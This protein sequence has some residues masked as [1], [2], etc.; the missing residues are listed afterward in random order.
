MVWFKVDDGFYEH[1][2]VVALERYPARI[3]ALALA[4]WTLAGSMSGSRLTDGRVEPWTLRKR[5]PNHRPRDLT[6][7][8]TALVEVGL[9]SRSGSTLVEVGSEFGRTCAG[10]ALYVFADWSQYQPTKEQVLAKRGRD[11]GRKRAKNP[12]VVAN[13]P[14][15]IHAESRGSPQGVAT[16]SERSPP[17]IQA[18]STAPEPEPEPVPEIAPLPPRAPPSTEEAEANRQAG[19]PSRAEAL[20][21]WDWHSAAAALNGAWASWHGHGFIDDPGLLSARCRGSL[22]GLLEARTMSREELVEQMNA[23]AEV[24]RAYADDP[25]CKPADFRPIRKHAVVFCQSVP[26][27]PE[28]LRDANRRTA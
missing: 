11:A 3:Q 23:F 16:E 19:R 26:Q 21:S 6:A 17:G 5:F 8:A 25:S 2:K 27:W 13:P 28:R 24:H 10:V 18:D 22:E 4:M 7:A 9:W 20:S 12:E 14:R 15:G 1:E